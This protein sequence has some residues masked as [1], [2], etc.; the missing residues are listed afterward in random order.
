MTTW[1]SVP[2]PHVLSQPRDD[3]LMVQSTHSI[4]VEQLDELSGG[5]PSH[6]PV[7]TEPLPC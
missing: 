7:A 6:K 4:P 1:S 3:S 5:V 2:P